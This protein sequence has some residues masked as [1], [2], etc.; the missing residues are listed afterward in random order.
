MK[1]HG[2]MSATALAIALTGYV[3]STAATPAS[4][5]RP[6]V[7]TCQAVSVQDPPQRWLRAE[8]RHW[9]DCVLSH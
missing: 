7:P 2:L 6:V 1:R 5:R 4:P 8:P 3:L 9:R